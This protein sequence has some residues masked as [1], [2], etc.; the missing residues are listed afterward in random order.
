MNNRG[1]DSKGLIKAAD[2]L[3]QKFASITP[4]ETPNAKPPAKPT[5]FAN[6]QL[7]LF[8]TFC[9]TRRKSGS[10]FQTRLISGTAFHGIP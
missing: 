1:S 3:E 8:Q 6:A 10:G 4:Q 2:I 5:E 7:S 9:A